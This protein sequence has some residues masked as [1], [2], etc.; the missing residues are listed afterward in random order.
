[1]P[2]ERIFFYFRYIFISIR[3]KNMPKENTFLLLRH[4]S[5]C[6]ASVNHYKLCLRWAIFFTLGIKPGNTTFDSPRRT[7][8]ENLPK[9]PFQGLTA[10]SVGLVGCF[11]SQADAFIPLGP[12]L[13]L[14]VGLF[15]RFLFSGR[16]FHPFGTNSRPFRR[17][18][19][20]FSFLRPTL[21]SF[22]S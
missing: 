3:S 20:P 22:W 21:S 12:T 7:I 19:P 16:R 1:M 11:S 15:R 6:Y 17:P 8:L 9:H 4:T 5:H 13:D 18:V 10:F 14:S 2:K